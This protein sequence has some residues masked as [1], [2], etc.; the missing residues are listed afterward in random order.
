MSGLGAGRG[1]HRVCR[2]RMKPKRQAELPNA[3]SAALVVPGHSGRAVQPRRACLSLCEL[4]TP[5]SCQEELD[6]WVLHGKPG[7]KMYHF[8]LRPVSHII[9]IDAVSEGNLFLVA[10]ELLEYASA[11]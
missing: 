4:G 7:G 3:H 5:A 11:S 10:C 2:W 9:N 1:G 6:H 8:P